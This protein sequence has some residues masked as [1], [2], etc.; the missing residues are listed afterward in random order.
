MAQTKT[1][2]KREDVVSKGKLMQIRSTVRLLTRAI[3][4]CLPITNWN[5]TLLVLS[6]QKVPMK[7]RNASLWLT[8][9]PKSCIIKLRKGLVV[10]LLKTTAEKGTYHRQKIHKLM[11][12]WGTF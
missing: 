4:Q 2:F 12:P 1:Y 6:E 11:L 7:R 10:A 8:S 5:G 9:E 3:S